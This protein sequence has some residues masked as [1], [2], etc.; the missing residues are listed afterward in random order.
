[1]RVSPTDGPT[2]RQAKRKE[3]NKKISLKPGSG[4]N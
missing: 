2:N 4:A 1:M 3:L